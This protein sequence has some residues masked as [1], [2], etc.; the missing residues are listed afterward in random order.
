ME[1]W[2][3][4]IFSS[5]G[6]YIL[7]FSTVVILVLCG[8]GLPIPEEATFLAAGYGASQVVGANVWILCLLGVI[9]IMLGDSIPFLL[10]MRYGMSI[11][12]HPFVA[13]VLTPKTLQRTQEFF[14]RHGA[15]TV[16]FARFVAGLR[17]PTFFV[18]ATMRVKYR[19]F[20]SW[21]LL[22]ALISCPTS[23]L[24]AYYYGPMAGE[25]LSKSK[26]VLFLAL[27]LFVA[28]IVFHYWRNSG[29]PPSTEDSAQKSTD[30]STGTP[31]QSV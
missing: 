14:D 11:L 16:F 22:G 18:A 3:H 2:L 8:M 13:R 10:G 17:M 12:K 25:L 27:G 4:E 15:K 23:I 21:D 24:L 29:T 1:N 19:T 20:F 31:N 7:Y 30:S 26:P 5:H 9:G 6:V 28:Y